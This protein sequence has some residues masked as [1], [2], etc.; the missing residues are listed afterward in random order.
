M[1]LSKFAEKRRQNLQNK[2][3][4]KWAKIRKYF[5]YFFSSTFLVCFFAGSFFFINTNNSN[6]KVNN[7]IQDKTFLL[8][9]NAY[10]N[11]LASIAYFKQESE[12]TLD[13]L[14]FLDGNNDLIKIDINL[15]SQFDSDYY[16]FK[17]I[18]N[19][20]KQKR[21]DFAS[22]SF[23]NYSEILFGIKVSNYIYTVSN[24]EKLHVNM[25]DTNLDTKLD[26]ITKKITSNNFTTLDKY[27]FISYN[28]SQIKT[29]NKDENDNQIQKFADNY[30]YIKIEIYNSTNIDGLASQVSRVLENQGFSV[31]RVQNYDK[32]LGESKIIKQTDN[33]DVFN[34]IQGV[35]N[36][37]TNSNDLPADI[38][39]VAD[40]VIIISGD[41][42]LLY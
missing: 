13:Y 37:S 22:T 36:I 8:K 21:S 10:T 39:S 6:K 3:N 15:Y 30:K 41:L 5:Y 18:L 14:Y 40:Y 9:K 16:Q 7:Y 12:G 17:D 4:I 33:N 20:I 31:V 32:Q 34:L 19:I 25:L 24:S 38:N 28:N 27:K 26:M 1:K 42:L 29:Y 23:F 11:K 35:L 2:K